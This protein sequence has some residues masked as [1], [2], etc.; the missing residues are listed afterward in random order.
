MVK[1]LLIFA[2]VVVL[3]FT[4]SEPLALCILDVLLG[5]FA[6]WLVVQAGKGD[7]CWVYLMSHARIK[8]AGT[9]GR[10]RASI[11]ETAGIWR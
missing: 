4:K 7:V 9:T 6:L 8:T 11:W 5:W 2:A 1:K 10:G 3:M